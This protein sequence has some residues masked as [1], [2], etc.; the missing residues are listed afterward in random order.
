MK[1]GVRKTRKGG[2]KEKNEWEATR[3]SR[4]CQEQIRGSAHIPY[5][6]KCARHLINISRDKS[7]YKALPGV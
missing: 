3:G 4:D 7:F 5:G 1:M 2:I 6:R